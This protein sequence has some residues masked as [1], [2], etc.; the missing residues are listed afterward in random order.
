[1]IRATQIFCAFIAFMAFILN[2]LFCAFMAL[3]P[4]VLCIYGTKNLNAI[5]AQKFL[6]TY[7]THTYL[8][9]L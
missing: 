6:C 8:S 9:L 7:N 4:Q 5:N 1:M 3:K 2:A